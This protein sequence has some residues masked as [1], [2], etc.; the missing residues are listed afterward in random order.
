M[1][2]NLED[3]QKLLDF[4]L[5]NALKAKVDGVVFTGD[6]FH[7]H[8]V[9]RIEV[10]DFWVR[11]LLKLTENNLK[12]IIIAGNHDMVGD[13]AKEGK[14]SAVTSLGLIP[15]VMVIDQKDIVT[16]PD[17]TVLALRAY[18]SDHALFINDCAEMKAKG[19][20]YLIAHQTFTG[21]TYSNGFYASDGIDPSLV[22]QDHVIS[23]HIH[24]SMQIGNCF[25]VGSPKADNM[26][27]AN[28][29]KGV[30]ILNFKQDGS[31]YSKEFLSTD[32]VVTC[33]KKFKIVE[34]EDLPVLN[35]AHK[36]Y[37]ELE[38][39]NIWITSMKKKLKNM[40]NLQIKAVPTDTKL[41]TSK[42]RV[43]DIED[44]LTN[45]FKPINGL[46]IEEVRQFIRG[47]DE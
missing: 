15:N 4:I 11:N 33:Y 32:A 18:T 21:A 27:D 6:L 36:N 43:T 22:A 30:W 2:S 19:A 34:G 8:A 37:L 3:S 45:Q 35:P 5:E 47:L 31:G 42:A 9:V 26:A 14:F 23:G 46:K 44:F 24:T 39:S 28:I 38:G 10:T 41:S 16:F 12:C 20:N 13:K 7:N 1:I 29:P 40:Q 17:K 25:Y